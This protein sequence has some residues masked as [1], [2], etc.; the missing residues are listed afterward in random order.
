[1]L[2]GATSIETSVL[3]RFFD[4][5]DGIEYNN[6]S[7]NKRRKRKSKRIADTEVLTINYRMVEV[8]PKTETQKQFF[9]E[10]KSNNVSAIGFAGTGKTFISTYLALKDVL[11][12]HRYQKLV[13]VRSA[14][15][16]RNVGFLPGKAEDKAAA[17]EAPYVEIVEKLFNR[18]CYE[19]LKSKGVIEFVLTSYLR[20]TT[21][22]NCVI[23][24]D[25]AQNMDEHEL[26]TVLTRVGQNAKVVLC[27]DTKQNDLRNTRE[28]SGLKRILE[29]FGKMPSMSVVTFTRDDVV[30]S[31]FV[32]EFLLAEDTT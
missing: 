32:R 31:G 3:T 16:T 7:K 24:I 5:L 15:Q 22:D 9:K 8:A 17:Y 12:H 19:T 2:N 13:I 30:R 29:I 23:L 1:M 26:K 14:V 27:G 18:D 6:N 25:E 4:P 10:Y 20:G 28:V 11:H 21:L